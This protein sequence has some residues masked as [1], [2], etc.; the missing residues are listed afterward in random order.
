[1]KK[2]KD[3]LLITG[4]Y[5]IHKTVKQKETKNF[6]A[7]LNRMIDYL[8]LNDGHC[9][10]KE[11][12][13]HLEDIDFN[14]KQFLFQISQYPKINY[15]QKKEIFQLKSEYNIQNIEELKNKIRSSEF[16]LLED[17]ELTDSY[18]GIKNDLDKLK[19]EKFAKVIVNNEKNCNVLF[20]RDMADNIE[21]I[22]IN[23]EYESALKELRKIWN[24]DMSNRFFDSTN[25]IQKKRQRS[26]DRLIEGN[27][28]IG[29]GQ[30]KKKKVQ[31]N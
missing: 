25:Y 8:R 10:K 5:N 1:M 14:S 20:Y 16:G 27:M 13:K 21:K 9:S 15:D 22:I 6:K 3:E 18:P 12:T 19:Q 7:V 31:M 2:Q 23:P 11:L 28:S 30:K 4:M 24:D 17:P 29:R 26:D